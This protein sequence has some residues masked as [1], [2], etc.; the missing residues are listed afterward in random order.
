ME[1]VVRKVFCSNVKQPSRWAGALSL[2]T[3]LLIGAIAPLAFGQT[4]LNDSFGNP[5]PL[6][7]D[8]GTVTADTRNATSETGEPSHAGLTPFH[9]LW[10]K[11]TAST[12]GPV[13][14]DTFNSS[15]DTVLAVYVGSTLPNLN[16]IVAN[17]DI[18]TYNPENPTRNYNPYAGP[19]GVKFNAVRGQT[20]F[21]AAGGKKTK[22]DP[23]YGPLV[24]SWAY[25]PS[26]VFRLSHSFYAA[27]EAES[28]DPVDG[29]YGP[30]A[31]GVRVTV[32]RL[33][34][35]SGKAIVSFDLRDGTG[36]PL[37][38]IG[39]AVQGIDWK[40]PATN[41]VIFDDYETSK[42]FVVPV[43]DD[44][45]F[46]PPIA[47]RNPGRYGLTNYP[48]KA[49]SVA[50]TNVVL[51]PLEDGTVLS[52]PR[53]DTARSAASIQIYDLDTPYFGGVTNGVSSFERVD[54]R[55]REG[56]G[57]AHIR[58]FRSFP[59]NNGA[60]E[61]HYV[62][63]SRW[64][65]E[66]TDDNKF[67]LM[68]GSDY[69][70]PILNSSDG[71]RDLNADWGNTNELA[72]THVDINITTTDG[73]APADPL[74][75]TTATYGT[76]RWNDGDYTPKTI[77]IPIIDDK[78]PEFNEDLQI[79]LFQLAGHSTDCELGYMSTANVTILFDDYPPGALDDTHNPD[80]DISTE[81][82][83]NPVPGTDN[84]VYALAV[85][86]NDNKTVIVG[87]FSTYNAYPRYGVARI[88]LDGSL[89]TTFNP[90]DGVPVKDPINPAFLTCL[91]YTPADKIVIGGSFPS[92]N[93]TARYN[94][95]RLNTD[96]SL[97]STFNPGLGAN[98]T[99]WSVVV[100]TNGQVL[101]GGEFTRVNGYP[102]AHIARLNT[103]GTLDQSFDPGATGPD[104][105]IYA[106][107]IDSDGSMYIG[108]DFSLVNGLY[109]SSIAKVNTNGV[110]VQSFSPVTGCDGPVYSL[111]LQKDGK[112]LAGGA[113]SN[114]EFRSRNNITRYNSDGSLDVSFDP[115][116]GTDDSVYSI[117]LQ[118][119]NRILLGGVF[120]VYNQ[121]RRI[122]LARLF[123][124]GELDTG[125]M[126]TA[127]NQF[128]GPHKNYYN[129]YVDPKDFLYTL[130]LQSDGN[131][132]VGGRF[133]YFGG[134]R[135][136][137][138]VATNSY[139]PFDGVGETRAAYRSRW[140]VTR[141][142]GGDIVGPG[143][144]SLITTNYSVGENMG[145]YF[146]KEVRQNGWLGQIESTF[147]IPPRQGSNT[148]GVAQSGVDY[149][150]NRVNPHWGTSY[151]GTRALSHGIFGTNNVSIDPLGGGHTSGL[152]DIYV[153]IMNLPGYQG[154]RSLP[155]KLDMPSYADQF[156]LGGEN[157]PLA[158]A[159]ARSSGFLNIQEDDVRPGVIGFAFAGF[160]VNENGTN[161]VITITR[162]NGST[163]VVPFLFAT[164]N[165][166]AV[167]GVD[168]IGVTNTIT[169]R[170][171]QT[172]T[173]VLIPINNDF[174]IEQADRTINLYLANPGNGA[175]LGTLS[176]AVLY[177]IDD[178]FL[179]GRINFSTTTYRTNEEAGALILT[180]TR[181][182]GNLG[183]LDVQY[184]SSNPVPG[185]NFLPVSGSFHWD[186]GD[187]TPRYIQ[188][189]VLHDGL[190]TPDKQ[191]TVQIF[192]PSVPGALGSRQWATNTIVNTDFYGTLQFSSATYNVNEQGGYAT[193]TVR[194]LG[195]SAETVSASFRTADS[196]AYENFN[197]MPT[198]G[199]LIFGP[200]EVSKS[201]TV[202]IRDDVAQDPSFF[203]FN[204][205]LSSFSPASSSGNPTVAFVNIV[206][207]WSFNQPPGQLDTYFNP[208]LFFNNDVYS[209]ALQ[210]D[211]KILV[212]GDFTI[213]S[214][215]PVNRIVRLSSDGYLDTTFLT[216][217]LS[218]ANGG[219]RTVVNQTDTRVVL[220]GE[221]TS[222]NG[223]ARNGVARLNYDGSL[224]TGFNPGS[225][226]G[227]AVYAVAETFDFTSPRKLLVG[228]A[229]STFNG[230]SS[231][232]LV[233]LND[234]GTV[235]AAFNTSTGVNGTVFAIAVYPTNSIFAGKTI[236]GGEFS[237]VNG[238]TRTR[239]A[240]LNVDGSL[241]LSFDPGVGANATVRALA[242]EPDGSVL[243]GGAFTN[244][245]GV[246]VNRIARLR[247]DGSIDPTFQPGVGCN[248][249]VYALT[250]QPDNRILVG[251]GFTRASDTTRNRLT[252]L[253][254]NGQVDPTINFGTGAS[255][256]VATIA[257]RP[258]GKL[259]VGGGFTEFQDVPRLHLVRLYGGSMVGSG[260]FRFS[261]PTY[262][263]DENATNILVNIIRT[264][265]S[266][267]PSLDG[268]GNI[269]VTFLTRDGTAVAGRNYST[270]VT[271]LVFPVG[272]TVKTVIVP[273]FDDQ[274]ITPDLTVNLALATPT[275]PATLGTQPT[276]LLTIFNVECAASFTSQTF[277]RA[278]D[279]VDGAAT[280][281]FQRVGS[282]RNSASILFSTTTNG[283]AIPKV[284]YTPIT[285]ALI[286]FAPG[287][288]TQTYKVPLFHTPVA[289]GD[290]TVGLQISSPFGAL[291][292]T[293]SV[294]TLTIV[295]VDSAPGTFVFSQTNYVIG[296]GDKYALIT[297]VR[298]NGRAGDV[299][300]TAM[301][302]PGDATPGLKYI[303]T[304]YAIPFAN[305]EVVKSFA[306]P[307][308]QEN[309]VEGSQS[310]FLLL[311]N[312]TGGT[313]IGSP[314]P[315]PLTILD[316]D[317]GLS[318]ATNSALNAVYI[319][320]ETN[321]MVTINVYRL[322]AP[323]D[324]VTTV[325]YYTTNGTAVAGTDYMAAS[326]TLTFNK[327]ESQKS[328][329][330]QI[331]RDPQVTGDL[332]FSV[333]L[334]SSSPG[335]QIAPP[336]TA[337]VVINDIDSG[338]SLYTTNSVPSTNVDYW[339]MENG[340]NVVI[341]VVRTNANTGPVR[342]TYATADGTAVA[343]IDY[344]AVSGTLAFTNGQLSNS[345]SIDIK[346]NKLVDG[347]RY[348]TFSLL[349][350]SAPA[351]L[352]SPTTGTVHI[353][354]NE[355]G[356]HF[357]GGSYEVAENGVA[358]VINVQR[359][360]FT[361]GTASVAFSTQNGTARAGVDYAATNGVLVF[362]N[363]EVS[364]SFAVGVIDNTIIDGDRTILVSL[365]NPQG[366]ATL[367]NPSAAT[368]TIHDNDGSLIIPA[369][370]AMVSENL[371]Q[372]K[373][374]EPGETVSILFAF[375]NSAGTNTV[376]LIATLLAT[377]G[378]TPV[379]QASQSYGVLVAE[380]PSASQPFT[381][382]ASG[383]NGQRI[384]ATFQLTDLGHTVSTNSGI[385][386]FTFT[387]GTST[388]SV[389]N[390]ALIVI[391]DAT[392]AGQPAAATPYPS[393][394]SAQGVDGVVSK[395][396]MSLK[397]YNHTSPSDVDVLLVSPDGV[398]SLL[399]ANAGDI[400]A[401]RVNLI[402]DDAATNTLAQTGNVLSGTYRP[403][404]YYP[405][406]PFPIPAPPA[407][408]GGRYT[409][410]LSAF[411]G[412]NP[413]GLWSLYVID[414]AYLD[415]GAISNG[416]GLNFTL[417]NPIVPASDV[418]I[419]MAGA[420]DTIV[421][422]SNVTY[423]IHA[424]SYGPGDAAGV[425]VTNFFPVGS[426]FVS[427]SST[428]G[429]FAT[430]GA[431]ALV[432]TL[433]NMPKGSSADLIVTL[434]P[435]SLGLITN[436]AV[437]GASS[438]DLNPD[439]DTAAVITT[440]I[441]Q[442]ADIALN[443]FSQ[444]EPALLGQDLTY[445]LVVSNLG[446]GSASDVAIVDRLPFGV[447]LVSANPPG[448]VLNG[449]SLTFTNLG[450]VGSGLQA[451]ATVVVR[452]LAGGTYT[453]IA[454]CVSTT[455]DPA[456]LN[457]SAAIKSVVDLL[458]IQFQRSAGSLTLA[459]PASAGDLVLESSTDLLSTNWVQV[460]D[461]INSVNGQK[462]ATIPIGPGNMFFRLRSP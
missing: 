328:I 342:V 35:S 187:T 380:G 115:G 135:F 245:N 50:L 266:M 415:S 54:Y 332:T 34:G 263:V 82:A 235:D 178:D 253:L 20:Y 126:D 219:V 141:V 30:S 428:A 394:I 277:Q 193:I 53:L 42:S 274:D 163:G 379:G 275:V 271:N 300:V 182:G 408:S 320:S 179:P 114:V 432:W 156:W 441:G 231:P 269:S 399:M 155:F 113:F 350:A 81:P 198:N 445:T 142:L 335:V 122:S 150:Y 268:S 353:I 108:G 186:D 207:A 256:Y 28:D 36:N 270:V 58:V 440:V 438:A 450:T 387:L 205:I 55:V 123:P 9:T 143:S 14:F 121:S 234:D 306:V 95:A 99:V 319:T 368:I 33:F 78:L 393:V 170:D 363:G 281:Q 434:L 209:V 448:W 423:R 133:H 295:D 361:N 76:L 230:V 37:M 287:E 206:D 453:N 46:N 237:A 27:S 67:D 355:T 213:V 146:I 203:G 340:T 199:S 299:S 372:N 131:L 358:A 90:G 165:G 391:N 276:A 112:L 25:H 258:D 185:D 47:V 137:V 164:T 116:S 301:T 172:V 189:P 52:P 183:V 244:V 442:T 57:V 139:P 284:N 366:S 307:V 175:T 348:F 44:S 344:V 369:G 437:A 388:A 43:I 457:N 190:V 310:L 69:A 321:S 180:V 72:L 407:P 61:I 117:V 140:N 157:I 125:F 250:L 362:T 459:W 29:S 222:I 313:A 11:W 195:G 184:A 327:G 211:G 227:G 352:L 447:A 85:H 1:T 171:G 208:N 265:G 147:S 251:G 62:I 343:P 409:N 159:R 347:D 134:G 349:N 91:A 439:D 224:D 262:E 462:V 309:Q 346:D 7:G 410:L 383:T 144:I 452:P 129:P 110:V 378:V 302:L 136:N 19:S 15:F 413:N 252:R 22:T 416:W 357:S 426:L 402:F 429:S 280:I 397:N 204:V 40:W 433:G 221:F 128:A 151:D 458:A 292:V 124:T 454:T 291:L 398:A 16:L 370:T 201:F 75:G 97:D 261:S 341:T 406:S 92:Y 317:V 21:I 331:L 400:P 158:S 10:F 12:D 279:A 38:G 104:G 86:A 5:Q 83:N 93:G 367:V 120:T 267:G 73:C 395:V 255:D 323:S 259:I 390:T 308:L 119:D 132:M 177:I 456:K 418:G 375:R 354:D 127:Y 56:V 188:V 145:F 316:D 296:E 232:G 100:Q 293:P 233:R 107:A 242:I 60:V 215:Q 404:V 290:T 212:G 254:P 236:I 325:S 425:S 326:G 153:T 371:T 101:I 334:A 238:I 243:L 168:Y 162:T 228:G 311:T 111:A 359:V 289:E 405:V 18:N 102:R 451:T 304:N 103:D 48:S 322:N 161:A 443:M 241:D 181:T 160:T 314:N 257:I 330:V 460:T 260:S 138:N 329:S 318:F 196:T 152:E 285:N 8:F 109:R 333:N 200:G 392:A 247:G 84:Q 376:N 403:S 248:D 6:I 384:V 298:T 436:S 88:N 210:P 249:V 427:A 315:V 461:G 106:I 4:P 70:H 421:L 360:G 154:D 2:G 239:I 430:N 365:S 63:S 59:A 77:D 356:F 385:A 449:T 223:V 337:N 420:A 345:F 381:F 79:Q 105:T 24:L 23:G 31:R 45:M 89:D 339:V 229:F 66:H 422:G 225:G 3:F 41:N 98:G 220:G 65:P 214:G 386:V 455:S 166:T 389:S 246:A 303:P 435:K 74:Y 401:S 278:E 444:P 226:A 412:S 80:W 286:T 173:N 382:T 351:Q 374:I 273:V 176:N 192:N 419:S 288:S 312:A 68:A 424:T 118:P 431:G 167:A 264:G 336:T 26:G 32:N 324:L 174:V 411:T 64:I 414:D 39:P 417:V 130:G 49:F 96:G 297:V 13:E 51:D 94:I 305:G 217:L 364:K 377:N 87:N 218:G 396:T 191:F 446:P 338:L 240:R 202:R 169:F 294:A 283:T 373:V 71:E 194:R 17:D 148:V 197:Y 272:E 216:T 149:V 282:V